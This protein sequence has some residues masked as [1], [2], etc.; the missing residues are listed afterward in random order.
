MGTILYPVNKYKQFTKEGKIESV[1]LCSQ[2][3]Q[4]NQNLKYLVGGPCIFDNGDADKIAAS[5]LHS[6]TL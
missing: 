3:T 2:T 5:K 6:S 4:A 1:L